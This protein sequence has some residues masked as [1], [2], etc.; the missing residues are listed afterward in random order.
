V[1]HVLLNLGLLLQQAVQLL[2]VVH[3]LGNLVGLHLFN[4]LAEFPE[5]RLRHAYSFSL[6]AIRSSIFVLGLLTHLLLLLTG[7]SLNGL[8]ALLR[9]G[10]L[11]VKIIVDTLDEHGKVAIL[12]PLLDQ[13]PIV[14]IGVWGHVRMRNTTLQDHVWSLEREIVRQR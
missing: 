11:L 3:V 6:V 8:S 14:G 5:T 4:A 13:R 1:F 7:L 10:W 9:H 2:L 12:I